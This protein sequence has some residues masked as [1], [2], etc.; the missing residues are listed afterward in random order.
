MRM[1][2]ASVTEVV[3]VEVFDTAGGR[4]PLSSTAALDDP[5]IGVPHGLPGRTAL[6]RAGR[7]WRF[8]E[9][10]GDEV[11]PQHPSPWLLLASSVASGQDGPPLERVALT[12]DE[13]VNLAWGVEHEIEGP[14]GR[15][16]RRAETFTDT[17]GA[18]PA[19]GAPGSWRYRL[20][21]PA[22]PWWIPL[23]PERLGDKTAQV[24]LRRSRVQSWELLDGEP[25]G[26]RGEL[27]DPRAPR[28]IAEEEVP[29]GGVEL[30]RT[31]QY[32]RWVD[33]SAHAWRQWRKHPGR[34][35]PGSG[36]RWDLTD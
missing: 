32:A 21:A 17:T 4:T 36:L 26:P 3:S 27:L 10:G 12:R 19:P 31:W 25:A 9:L 22:P 35:M 8:F 33:G 11:G 23:R 7:A 18:P 6:P 24:R 14:L 15:G 20:E 28:W 16:M 2:A 5:A 30:R 29:A 13:A 34:P 1:P